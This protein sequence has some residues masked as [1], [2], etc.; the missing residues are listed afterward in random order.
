MTDEDYMREALTEARKA[1]A[2]GEVPVGA[3]VVKDGMVVGRGFNQPISSF[4][5][6]A[7]AEIMALRDAA[8]NLGNY[9][10]VDSTLYITFEPCAMCAGAIFHAR[11]KRVVYG[12]AEY[13]TGAAGSIVN[14]FAE[15]R[16]NFHAQIEGG[17]LAEECGKLVSDFFTERRAS[18][19]LGETNISPSPQPAGRG[20]KNP[21]IQ[22]PSPS[23]RGAGVREKLPH[24]KE[25]LVPP[26]LLEN[27]R[28]LRQTQ[29]DAETLLWY[30]LRNRKFGGAKFRR[31]HP[32]GNYVLDFYCEAENLAIE[33]DGGQHIEQA[34]YDHK[35]SVDLS[36]EGIR[37][38]RFWNHEMFNETEAVLS[39]IWDT[40]F[41]AT[42]DG[43]AI[44]PS[45]QPS[46][47]GRVPACKLEPFD[48]RGTC[49]AKP[50]PH[51]AGRGS[52]KQSLPLGEGN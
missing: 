22:N 34:K 19:L 14:L 17:V 37:I 36:A 20:G 29:T 24:T 18:K 27:A 28:K 23:G 16:L 49:S 51:P 41:L 21:A 38:L 13:K 50:L 44:S 32:I 9:R 45:P 6:S 1:W 26:R 5:P 12:A 10:L 11:V 15:P 7:H 25:C 8:K 39:V 35:R 46:L 33:L 30:F 3:I 43:A 47:A 40:L 52:K 48:R 31:Q 2:A 4:D 42:D